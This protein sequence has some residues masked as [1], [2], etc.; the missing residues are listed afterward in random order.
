M[1]D[2][3]KKRSMALVLL[4]DKEHTLDILETG[5]FVRKKME[6]DTAQEIWLHMRYVVY[7]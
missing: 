4:G 3:L 7:L 6:Q 2:Y 1:R 5:S